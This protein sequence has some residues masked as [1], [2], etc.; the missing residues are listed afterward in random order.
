E[1]AA[2]VAPRR[3]LFVVG[4]EPLFVAGPGSHIDEMITL[5]AGTN[6]FQ[7]AGSPYER[8]SMEVALQRMP[9]VIIDTSDNRPGAE[10]GRVPGTWAR[11]GF[12]PAVRENRVWQIDP[13][14]LVIP[15]IR[16]PEMSAL[17]GKLVHPE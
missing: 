16:L 9:E 8:V 5:V 10:R 11:W 6:V 12:L 13:A 14:R 2:G 17:M 15:G 1:Q 4:R 3:V 7:D